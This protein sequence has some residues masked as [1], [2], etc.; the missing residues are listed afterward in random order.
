MV[1]SYALQWALGQVLADVD[2]EDDPFEPEWQTLDVVYKDG[3]TVDDY[4]IVDKV[5]GTEFQAWG[6]DGILRMFKVEDYY[7]PEDV[8]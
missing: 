5:F 1:L 4:V 2:F 7:R 6:P 8:L 3:G